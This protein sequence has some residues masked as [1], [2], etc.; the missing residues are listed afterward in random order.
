MNDKT[1]FSSFFYIVLF[2]NNYSYH[3]TISYP[4]GNSSL[5]SCFHWKSLTL[6]PNHPWVYGLEAQVHPS[7]PS[8][9]H[10]SIPKMFDFEK[11]FRGFPPKKC[12]LN[13]PTPT[14][15]LQPFFLPVCSWAAFKASSKF[16]FIKLALKGTIRSAPRIHRN[17]K[18]GFCYRWFQTCTSWKMKGMYIYIY[19]SNKYIHYISVRWFLRCI[20]GWFYWMFLY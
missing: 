2:R 16:R 13:A 18:V 15:I 1:I 10:D 7:S 3:C 6:N 19:T 11:T 9:S 20:W 4:F 8:D 14:Q 17:T 5:T 12:Y